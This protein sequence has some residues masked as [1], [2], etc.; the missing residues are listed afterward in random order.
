REVEPSPRGS[1]AKIFKNFQRVRSLDS[2]M[3]QCV[4]VDRTLEKGL[5]DSGS[6]TLLVVCDRELI[7]LILQS[8]KFSIEVGSLT[9]KLS[10]GLPLGT[11]EAKHKAAPQRGQASQ[12][13]GSH[14]VVSSASSSG[15]LRGMAG[16]NS[17]DL[18]RA[19]LAPSVPSPIAASKVVRP[20][21]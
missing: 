15:T 17:P 10:A 18:S 8:H 13:N 12:V 1:L 14:L 19:R 2:S 3:Q 11:H 21:G 6:M 4:R 5:A 7:E 20:P 9:C 16:V